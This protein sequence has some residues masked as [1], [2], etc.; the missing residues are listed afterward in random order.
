MT[1]RAFTLV[2]ILLAV[3]LVGI[4]TTLS[5]ATMSA[6]SR[7]W[8]ISADYIDK[9]QR[10]DYALA[11]VVSGLRSM[12]YPHD[13]SQDYKYGFVLTD[14]G[15]GEDPKSSDVIEWSKTGT[16][17]VGNR[18]AVADTVHRVQVM[19]LEEGNHD[20]KDEIQVT[21]LYARQCPDQKL[22]PS[23]DDIDYTFENG[24]MYQ[25]VL[26]ADGIVGFSCRVM[27]DADQIDADAGSAKFDE[28][29]ESSNSVPY[30]IEL[31]FRI[32]DPEG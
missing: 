7:G 27:K 25:P 24:E 17:I 5:V 31:T 16:A 13:G 2:E 20:Y 10:T 15:D 26:I 23:D 6:V 3:V 28:E 1:R 29:W 19:V 18:S 9:M 32:A 22:R 12:Y 8:E 14:N 30:K 4:I 11:Q 21:G